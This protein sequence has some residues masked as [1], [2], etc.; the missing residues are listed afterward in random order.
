[1][2]PKLKRVWGV[3]LSWFGVLLGVVVFCGAACFSAR[4]DIADDFLRGYVLIQEGD[5][6]EKGGEKDVAVQK[7]SAALKVLRSVSRTQPDWNPNIISYRTKYCA[8]HVIKNGGKVEPEDAETV[9]GPA[10]GTGG[11]AV[12]PPEPQPVNTVPSGATPPAPEKPAVAKVEKVDKPEK[13]EVVEKVE[14]PEKPPPAPVAAVAEKPSK[15]ES[16]A[17][18]ERELEKAYAEARVAPDREDDSETGDLKK[19]LRKAEDQ[20]HAVMNLSDERIRSLTKENRALKAEL[21]DLQS[22][23]QSLQRDYDSVKNESVA[24]KRDLEKTQLQLKTTLAT[25][26]S[27]EELSTLQRENSLLRAI[28]ERQ[29][30]EEQKRIEAGK[31][32]ARYVQDLETQLETLVHPSALSQEEIAVMRRNAGGDSEKAEKE[33]GDATRLVG[34]IKVDADGKPSGFVGKIVEVNVKENFVILNFYPGDVPPAST[35]M[36]VFRGANVVGT[37]RMTGAGKPP[38]APAEIVKGT[39]RRG[40]MV[41][42]EAE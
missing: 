21:A 25:G 39:L 29:Y 24:L 41:R 36:E 38:V 7:F 13:T 28:T 4:G 35:E 16:S 22:Q 11:A 6:A 40:D 32:V 34:T 27:S 1:M 12:P 9:G 15:A 33:G 20:L 18:L 14:T 42:K 2:E 37:V 31:R 30:Q 5:Q 10:G 19:R 17:S 8:E 3:P 23:L 26:V